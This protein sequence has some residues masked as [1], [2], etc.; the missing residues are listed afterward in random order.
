MMSL[1]EYEQIVSLILREVPKSLPH[2]TYERLLERIK[3]DIGTGHVTVESYRI[4]E[5]NFVI[6]TP[7]KVMKLKDF[8][9]YC[10]YERYTTP[11]YPATTSSYDF[12]DV[13]FTLKPL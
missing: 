9:F 6:K 1:E 3:R 4:V 11:R 7:R 2:P 5:K 8:F 12:V 10:E 13:L